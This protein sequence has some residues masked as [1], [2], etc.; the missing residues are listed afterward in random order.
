MPLRPGCKTLGGTPA[1]LADSSISGDLADPD[2]DGFSNLMDYALGLPPKGQTSTNRPTASIRNGYLTL[3]YTRSKA[4][5]DVSVTVEGSNDLLT[6]VSRA[7]ILEQV[8]CI[9]QG[10]TE[11]VTVQL[12]T[13]ASAVRR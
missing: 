1:E 3:T 8:S 10:A 11:L 12:T 2:H 6:W 13:P 4:A 7:N 9:D 5:T